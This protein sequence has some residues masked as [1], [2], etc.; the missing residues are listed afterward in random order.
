MLEEQGQYAFEVSRSA[1][2]KQIREA[3]KD[4]YGVQPVHV[5]VMPIRSKQVR[6]GRTQGRTRGGK[7]ALITLPPGQTLPTGK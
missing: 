6:Y 3:I 5:N 7:K 2:K 4:L 1:N